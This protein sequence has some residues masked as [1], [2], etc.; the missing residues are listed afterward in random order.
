MKTIFGLFCVVS[1]FDVGPQGHLG[2][3]AGLA[4]SRRSW[5][6]YFQRFDSGSAETRRPRL[7]ALLILRR[8]RCIALSSA[9]YGREIPMALGHT[10]AS[11]DRGARRREKLRRFDLITGCRGPNSPVQRWTPDYFLASKKARRSFISSIRR[12]SSTG[13]GLKPKRR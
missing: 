2:H 9:R 7:K 12:I 11:L 1:R 4:G 5:V 8:R 13:D 3:P 6:Q 10:P